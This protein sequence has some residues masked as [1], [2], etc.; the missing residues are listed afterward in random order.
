MRFHRVSKQLAEYSEGEIFFDIL[1]SSLFFSNFSIS[2]QVTRYNGNFY[3]FFFHFYHFFLL[4]CW[5]DWSRYCW[6]FTIN[7]PV[8]WILLTKFINCFIWLSWRYCPNMLYI[9]F[10]IQDDLLR[11]NYTKLRIHYFPWMDTSEKEDK[12]MACYFHIIMIVNPQPSRKHISC[13]IYEI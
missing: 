7:V 8:H 5:Y 13:W 9:V 12:N 6:I 4:I 2:N 3:L 10:H 11:K 1:T